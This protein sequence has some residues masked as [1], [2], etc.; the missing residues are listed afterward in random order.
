MKWILT[1]DGWKWL[2]AV[3]YIVICIF[4]FILVPMWF[5]TIRFSQG[6]LTELIYNISDFEPDIQRKLISSFTFQHEPFTLR[7][8]GIFHLAF[9]AL[10][11]GSAINRKEIR[12]NNE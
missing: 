8:G 7:G 4:D 10:L 11:T 1:S 3:T 2:C 5:G 9:G 12:K 6:G